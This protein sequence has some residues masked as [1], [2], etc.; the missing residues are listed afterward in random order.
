MLKHVPLQ[1]FKASPT[2]WSLLLVPISITV[3]IWIKRVSYLVVESQSVDPN[4]NTFE[5]AAY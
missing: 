4:P 5:C 1:K 2:F 3:S